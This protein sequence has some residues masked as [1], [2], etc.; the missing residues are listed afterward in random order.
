MDMGAFL[1]RIQ[2]L[3]HLE[4]GQEEEVD[5]EFSSVGSGGAYADCSVIYA[6]AS[7]SRRY[8]CAHWEGRKRTKMRL[9]NRNDV[10]LHLLLQYYKDVI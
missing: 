8:S 4:V 2:K 1:R 7:S 3:P 6:H 10:I 5:V 9:H